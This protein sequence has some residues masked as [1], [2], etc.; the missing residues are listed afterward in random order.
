VAGNL[1]A[2]LTGR[3]E[4]LNVQLRQTEEQYQKKL[5][6]LEMEVSTGKQD[7]ARCTHKMEE[8]QGEFGKME[9]MLDQL[10]ADH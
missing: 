6:E 8:Y 9:G 3:E 2:Q 1:E 10:Q 4:H 5:V 7:L